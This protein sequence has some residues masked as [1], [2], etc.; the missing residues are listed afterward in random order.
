[1]KKLDLVIVF[2][3][4]KETVELVPVNSSCRVFSKVHAN[5]IKTL[6]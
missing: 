1:M 2:S 3:E 5:L 4:H 6:I